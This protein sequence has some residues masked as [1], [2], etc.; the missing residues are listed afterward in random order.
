MNGD[1][2]LME[3]SVLLRPLKDNDIPE[4]ANL[5]YASFNSWYW[6]HG[7][8]K[9]YFGCR[10]QETS[11]F[12]EIYN[13][14]TPGC[15]IA[16]FENETGR[17]MGSCFYHPREHHV[18]LGIMSVHPNY[19]GRGIGRQLVNFILNYTK[20]N[21]YKSCRLVS[22]AINMDSLSLYNRADFVPRVT[23]HDMVI[24]VPNNSLA[25]AGDK[26]EECIREAIITDIEKMGDLE[27]EVSGIRRKIDY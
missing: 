9:D 11:I 3:K 19:G 4:H 27:M 12:Y 7:W 23:Y 18:S 13:D 20:I 15:S 1:I 24:N 22:S 6:K 17:M 8:G 5:L 14:L 10:P 21:D 2:Y 25:N 26:G 16:A